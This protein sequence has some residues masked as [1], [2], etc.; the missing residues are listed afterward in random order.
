VRERCRQ[1]YAAARRRYATR[2]L[3]YDADALLSA[4]RYDAAAMR[5]YISR[6]C[7]YTLPLMLS[8]AR[9]RD[10]FRHATRD[11]RAADML[12]R[13]HYHAVLLDLRFLY[14]LLRHATCHTM[15]LY[16][17]LRQMPRRISLRAS[18]A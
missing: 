9:R 6:R 12:P 4:F 16:A 1:R 15:P 14:L 7:R 10:Y 17:S 8:S 13:H 3:R 18:Y 2:H 11:M 5:A